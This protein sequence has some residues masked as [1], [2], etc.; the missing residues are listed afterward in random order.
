MTSLHVVSHFASQKVM[1]KGLSLKLI[2]KVEKHVLHY[3]PLYIITFKY[4]LHGEMQ[5]FLLYFFLKHTAKLLILYWTVARIP[6]KNS[7]NSRLGLKS[8]AIC[9]K[10]FTLVLLGVLSGANCEK[11]L[12]LML[13]FLC[14]LV[15]IVLCLGK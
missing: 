14:C 10:F 11:D 3:T 13:V 15:I 6:V 9:C 4:L 1:L 7:T 8:A 2:L 12:L 5:F